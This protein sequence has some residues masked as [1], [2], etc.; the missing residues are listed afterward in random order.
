MAVALRSWSNSGMFLDT[1]P[2]TVTAPAGMAAGDFIVLIA[3]TD[4]DY[5]PADPTGFG[6]SKIATGS[7]ETGDRITVWTKV[8]TSD[9]V[10]AGSFSVAGN[11][12]ALMT[13]GCAAF[14]GASTT[15]AYIASYA[16]ATAT[17]AGYTATTGDIIYGF[18]QRQ[19][20]SS[21]LAYS[22]A[23]NNPSWDTSLFNSDHWCIDCEHCTVT[24][25]GATGNISYAATDS[26][27]QMVVLAVG[28]FLGD[29]P[30][31][32]TAAVTDI[33][34]DSATSGGTITDEGGSAVT[35]YGVCWSS[36]NATPTLADCDGYTD[37]S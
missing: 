37:D 5:T 1:N 33:T 11:G 28:A 35:A 27:T 15:L 17:V 14:T 4:T 12:T 36:T 23:N 16:G 3:L 34:S 8:A 2:V 24:T 21:N 9:D 32:S 30:T 19:G 10:T 6:T 22:L 29:P 13:V 25:D 26:G 7:G 31:V 18:M 20:G